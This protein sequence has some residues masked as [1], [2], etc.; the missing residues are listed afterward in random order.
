VTGRFLDHF[1]GELA[2]QTG[3]SS[4]LGYLLDYLAGGLSYA[5]LFLGMAWG[6]SRGPLGAWALGLGL[7]GVLCAIAA[8]WI[9]M[10]IDR[11]RGDGNAVGYPRLGGFELE[12]GVYLLAPITWLGW[13]APFFVVSCLGALVYLVY[14]L[15]A[16]VRARP[17]GQR[18]AHPDQRSSS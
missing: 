16:M 1:D 2:R 17:A 13:L 14:A 3:R 18:P 6:L 11:I 15:V 12:D 10:R 9:N 5:A 8:V 7:V 4:R